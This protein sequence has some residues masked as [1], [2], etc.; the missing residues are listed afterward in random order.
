MIE[1]L[2]PVTRWT[3]SKRAE[4]LW[5]I[6]KK[7]VTV[8]EVCSAHGL[9]E[10]IVTAWQSYIPPKLRLPRTPR[11]TA[12]L[13]VARPLSPRSPRQPVL[14][15]DR[16]VKAIG[17]GKGRTVSRDNIMRALYGERKVET[18]ILDVV[19]SKIR[20]KNPNCGIVTV[21]GIGYRME[22]EHGPECRTQLAI[23][24]SGSGSGARPVTCRLDSQP[25][26]SV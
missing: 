11:K 9:T 4:V 17:E 19:I 23:S 22:T 26:L 2:R 25:R 6:A 13:R 18:N 10:E 20:S 21:W 15:A 7:L 5:A 16:I 3:D 14:L 8:E 1:V 24:N 12:T